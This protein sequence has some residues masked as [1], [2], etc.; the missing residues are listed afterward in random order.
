MGGCGDASICCT[1]HSWQGWRQ[2]LQGHD[3]QGMPQVESGVACGS[4]RCC[5]VLPT[6]A[7][8]AS[9][10]CPQDYEGGDKM[11]VLPCQH[12]FHSECVDQWLSNRHPV[13]PVCKADAHPPATGVL[14]GAGRGRAGQEGRGVM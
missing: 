6:F 14:A 1:T 8:L 7:S 2:P 12:R 10:N 11:R 13:C 5:Y 3:M 9:H 4:A